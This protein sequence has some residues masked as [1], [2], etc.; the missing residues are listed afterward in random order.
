VGASHSRTCWRCFFSWRLSFA[1]WR[2]FFC[3]AFSFALWR[4]FFPAAIFSPLVLFFCTVSL[5]YITIR[6]AANRRE[7]QLLHKAMALF[8]LNMEQ[9]FEEGG[10]GSVCYF[11]NP[12]LIAWESLGPSVLIARESRQLHRLVFCRRVASGRPTTMFDALSAKRQDGNF[13]STRG[14][15]YNQTLPILSTSL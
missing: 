10:G 15:S 3:G 8:D 2:R 7:K 5:A 4:R 12:L 9:P 1:L 13:C 11:S 14:S 6:A